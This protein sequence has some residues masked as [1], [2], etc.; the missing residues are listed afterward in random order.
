MRQASGEAKD[1]VGAASWQAQHSVKA[2]ID[3]PQSLPNWILPWPAFDV[4]WERT[5]LMIIDYQNYSSNPEVGTGSMLGQR[6]PGVAAY[7]LPRITEVTIPNTRRLLDAFRQAGREVIFTRHGALLTDGRD[8]IPRRR[9]RD[10]E[11]ETE[12]DEPHMFPPGT[13]EHQ[14]IDQLAPL[15]HELVVNKNASSPFNSTG[16]DQLL[17]NIGIETLIVTGVATDMCVE[18]TSRDAADRGYNVIVVEDAVA[19]FFHEHHCAALSSLARVFTK[20]WDTEQVLSA[21]HGAL[22]SRD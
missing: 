21:L 1:H 13:Y 7:Y 19:T 3:S 14:I 9:R 16:I 22:T 6:H 11:M 8:M 15:P 5:A 10:A 12:I 2:E 20:V 17:R 18:N 4:D